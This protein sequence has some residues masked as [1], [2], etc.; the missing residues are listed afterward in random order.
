[1]QGHKE[2]LALDE[3]LKLRLEPELK[4]KVSKIAKRNRKATAQWLREKLWQIVEDD[5]KT[6]GQRELVLAAAEGG[7]E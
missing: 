2:D 7:R 5:E 1:M 3:V 6:G 4:E